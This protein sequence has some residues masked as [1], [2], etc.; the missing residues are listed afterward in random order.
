[1]SERIWTA[2]LVV[3]GDEILSGR[4]Q[5]KN[6]AQVAVWLNVQGIRLAEA[7]TADG[8]RIEAQLPKHSQPDYLE[9]FYQRLPLANGDWVLRVMT[10]LREAGQAATLTGYF[11]GG[12]LCRR[13]SASIFCSAR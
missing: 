6:V 8:A 12:A 5:D 7:M 11:E 3:I 10:P 1:M 9:P 4:T 13:G 2:A